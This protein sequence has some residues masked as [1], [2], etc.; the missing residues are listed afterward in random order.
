[1]NCVVEEYQTSPITFINWVYK[2]Q[3]DGSVIEGIRWPSILQSHC[4]SEPLPV[5]VFFEAA[6]SDQKLP[7]MIS[8]EGKYVWN[9][10]ANDHPE[11]PRASL[12]ILSPQTL[13]EYRIPYYWDNPKPG[14]GIPINIVI[15]QFGS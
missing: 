14:V 5:L 8:L 10:A 6:R 2:L 7:A 3:K 1:M 11:Y 15:G 13:D 9:S 4:S 12:E